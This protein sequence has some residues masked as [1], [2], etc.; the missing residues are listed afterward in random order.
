MFSLGNAGQIDCIIKIIK[1]KSSKKL[2]ISALQREWHR[3]CRIKGL[4]RI[5]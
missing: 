1:V 5:R 3:H 2:I 4:E